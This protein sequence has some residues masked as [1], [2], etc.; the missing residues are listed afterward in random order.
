[1]SWTEG[2]PVAAIPRGAVLGLAR[3]G[4]RRAPILPAVWIRPRRQEARI[5][6]ASHCHTSRSRPDSSVTMGRVHRQCQSLP[7]V[8]E[9][10]GLA[11]GDERRAP[12]VSVAATRQE[13]ARTRPRRREARTGSAS[14]RHMSQSRSDSPATTGDVH[15]QCKSPPHITE[16]FKLARDD[17]RR[18]PPPH[19]T[20]PFGHADD[21]RRCAP[22]PHA[23][24]P[25]GLAR[26]DGRRA[27][28]APVAAIR[29]GAV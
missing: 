16:P 12:A 20:K 7:H 17:G 26:D 11:R 10:F 28:A 2:V 21:D 9:S 19:V 14:R 24:E 18:A 5:G 22:P 25:F 3:R 13:A 27:P 15:R 6:S 4:G 8:K 23:A 1:M 29:H